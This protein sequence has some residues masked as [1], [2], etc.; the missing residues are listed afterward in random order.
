VGQPS[1][2]STDAVLRPGLAAIAAVLCACAMVPPGIRAADPSATDRAAVR[3]PPPGW[4]RVAVLPF[5]GDPAHRRPA[6][7]LVAV[8][9]QRSTHLA[10]V[11][12][13]A[14][15]QWFRWSPDQAA[16]ALPDVDRWVQAYLEPPGAGVPRDELRALA[17]RVAAEAIVIGR[18]SPGGAAA[19]LVL[20]DA[21]TGEAVAALRRAGS[22]RAAQS[23]VHELAMSSTERAL[24]D[25]VAVLQTPPGRVPP[26]HTPEQ[27][28]ALASGAEP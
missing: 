19:D 12:P 15:Q 28:D 24:Q 8:T 10:L 6:E 14:V 25:L 2:S 5:A 20:V 3:A 9:L 11:P 18:V 7:E 4:K 23:G 17:T 26:V 13:Y 21:A 1:P 16:A 22:A 27:R